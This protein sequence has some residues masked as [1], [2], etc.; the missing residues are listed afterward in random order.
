M[1]DEKCIPP[2]WAAKIYDMLREECNAPPHLR[3]DFIFEQGEGCREFRFQGGL[4]FGGKFYVSHSEWRVDCYTEDLNTTRRAMMRMA[5]LRLANMR[6]GFMTQSQIA[7]LTSQLAAVTRERDDATKELSAVRSSYAA[8]FKLNHQGDLQSD[9]YAKEADDLRNVLRIIDN[10]INDALPYTPDHR[11]RAP[12]A[13]ILEEITEA[14]KLTTPP[15]S[16]AK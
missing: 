15:A 6:S 13:M 16:E 11:A 10:R 8:L 1:P 2:E 5:N 9:A 14:M 4:G 7:S 12:L 3:E